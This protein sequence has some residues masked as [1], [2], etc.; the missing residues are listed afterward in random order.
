[1]EAENF[2]KMNQDL[3]KILALLLNLSKCS[4]CEE[5]VVVV[6]VERERVVVWG[7]FNT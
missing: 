3:T 7:D 4:T 2:V 6:V 5:T 1:M